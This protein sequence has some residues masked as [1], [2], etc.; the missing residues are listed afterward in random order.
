MDRGTARPPARTDAPLGLDTHL[1]YRRLFFSASISD[2][3]FRK[4]VTTSPPAMARRFSRSNSRAARPTSKRSSV[5]ITDPQQVT[6][7]A[8]MRAGN[9]Q[10]YLYMLLYAAFLGCGCLA[11]WRELR[12]RPLLAAAALP[13]VAA[14]CDAWENWLLF[15]I[16]AAFTLGDYS[17]AMASLPYPVAAKFLLLATTNVAI[18]AGATQTGAVVGAVRDRRDP[19]R[20]PDGDG[21]HHPRRLCLGADSVGRRRLDPAP[22]AR[23]D[24]QLAGAGPGPPARRLR[25]RRTAN[26]ASCAPPNRRVAA[27]GRRRT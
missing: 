3:C 1:R 15:D 11:L 24:R 10:D 25:R 27:F 4:R 19:R 26:R 2:R 8:A 20:N 5:S 13:V 21:D 23:C 6:R 18:G 9:E 14:L 7:L 16:Q 17:P 12:L 22:R